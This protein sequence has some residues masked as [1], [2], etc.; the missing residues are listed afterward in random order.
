MPRP[1]LLLAAGLLGLLGLLTP[2]AGAS[3]I[4]YQGGPGVCTIDPDTAARRTV[5]AEGRVAGITRDGTGVG[6]VDAAG[7]LVQLRLATGTHTVVYV[8]NQPTMAPDGRSILWW[9]S[10]PD[11]YGNL[12]VDVYRF[13]VGGEATGI[14]SCCCATSHGFLDAATALVAFPPDS[15]TKASSKICRIASGPGGSCV[16]S[17]AADPRGTHAWPTGSPDGRQI[18]ASVSADP[19]DTT[20]F[21]G[22]IALY[23]RAT[24][25]LVGDITTGTDDSLPAWSPDAKR[26]VFDRGEDAIV[27]HTLAT[28]EERILAR[29]FSP[30]W[31]GLHC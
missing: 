22:R 26:I 8:G 9:V 3:T 20:V 7:D 25:T 4:V 2:G 5:A 28:G 19:A 23:S 6:D 1:P 18:L 16:E 21:D 13:E 12:L 27:V 14:S 31:G 30:S 11:L 29:G 10:I 24:G 15:N 17:Y